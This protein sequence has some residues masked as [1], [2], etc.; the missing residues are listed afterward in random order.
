VPKWDSFWPRREFTD[1][2]VAF[3]YKKY[4]AAYSSIQVAVVLLKE[5]SY[6]QN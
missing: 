5:L 6:P 2:R 4:V 3:A 1:W